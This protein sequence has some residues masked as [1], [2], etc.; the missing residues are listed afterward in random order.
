MHPSLFSALVQIDPVIE[1]PE[2]LTDKVP[3]VASARRVDV[4]PSRADAEDYFRSRKF[5]KSW[6]PRVLD[7][8]LV[9]PPPPPNSPYLFS[10]PTD[11]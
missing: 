3:A 2:K 4:W 6:D 9:P 5:F 8:H 11:M 7:A 1:E 10:R